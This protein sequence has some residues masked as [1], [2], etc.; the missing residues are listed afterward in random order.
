MLLQQFVNEMESL[1]VNFFF[2]KKENGD[3]DL[4]L[5]D[6]PKDAYT[7]LLYKTFSEFKE[8][9]IDFDE[10]RKEKPTKVFPDK[11][12]LWYNDKYYKSFVKI[13]MKYIDCAFDASKDNR[14]NLVVHLDQEHYLQKLCSVSHEIRD[15][16][17]SKNNVICN[18]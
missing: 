7:K 12:A 18:Y 15:A 14:Y 13:K 4:Y 10:L 16:F 2:Y 1:K 11:P 17:F 5:L 8:F 3:I 9:E 6:L